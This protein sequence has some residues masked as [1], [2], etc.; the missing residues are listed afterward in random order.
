MNTNSSNT[1]NGSSLFPVHCSRDARMTQL[2]FPILYTVVFCLGVIMNSVS[3]WIFFQVPSK[4]VFIVYLKNTVVADVIMTLALLFKILTDSGIAP[5]QVK[6]FVC[7]FSAVIFYV[8]MY[9]N[10]IL[11]GFIGF[12]R[13]LKIVRPFRR[14]S[15]HRVST[16]RAISLTVWIVMFGLSVPNMILTSEEATPLTVR[17][18]T[19]LKTALGVKWHEAV[20]YISLVIFWTTFISLT[21]F[22]TVIS[23][24]VYDS[25][26]KS[27]SKQTAARKNTKAK[28]FIVIIVFFLCFAP[29]HF[30]RMPYTY[31]QTGVI[32]DCHLSNRLF[33]AKESTL[34]VA[35]TNVCMDPLIYVLL[36]KPF[37]KMLPGIMNSKISSLETHINNESTV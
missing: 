19:D 34:W 23:K 13:F 15:M 7:R 28:V 37:R 1:T 17:K 9:I 25:Y 14:N 8:T 6:A 21:L 33:L 35:A 10:I 22:Y 20:N 29:F 12:D 36:C 31:S 30:V 27:H 3:V 5:W 26:T 32:K 24:K 11:L 18:C 16:A 2:V 4:S